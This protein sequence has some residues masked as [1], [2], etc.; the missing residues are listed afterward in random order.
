M[1]T[2]YKDAYNSTENSY[3]YRVSNTYSDLKQVLET[4][5]NIEKYDSELSMKQPWAIFSVDGKK[6]VGEFHTSN[7]NDAIDILQK[8]GMVLLFEGGTWLWPGVRIGFQRTIEIDDGV[9][10][11]NKN[12]NKRSI[13]IET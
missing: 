8:H 11:K 1:M 10:S 6:L 2:F 13:T 3:Q 9:A 12:N 4:K 7:E 5:M